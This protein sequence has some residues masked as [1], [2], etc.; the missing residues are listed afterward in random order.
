MAGS[1]PVELLQAETVVCRVCDPTLSML[2][3][4]PNKGGTTSCLTKG[5]R[6]C[7]RGKAT[8]LPVHTALGAD[9]LQHS[10]QKS[11]SN[12]GARNGEIKVSTARAKDPP[13]GQ[14]TASPSLAWE[15]HDLIKLSNGR[16]ERQLML[17]PCDLV[18]GFRSLSDS[19][20]TKITSSCLSCIREISQE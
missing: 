7:H 15:L 12:P 2:F 6:P 4:L 3:G 20:L 14:V 16:H 13:T 5:L 11:H 19:V 8:G 10:K 17:D 9:H 18:T 1:E